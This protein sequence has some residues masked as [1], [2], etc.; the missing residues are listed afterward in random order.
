[1]K[2]VLISGFRGVVNT[3]A[4]ERLQALPTRDD[5]LVDLADAV[6][7]DIDDSGRISRRRGQSLVIPGSAH[8]L[9]SDGEH[10]LYIQD[11]TM[12]RLDRELV[13]HAV[14]LGLDPLPMSYVT[15]GSRVYHSNGTVSAV[16]EDG[17]VR[18]W[19][20]PLSATSATASLISGTM[21]AGT[22]LFAMTLLREDGQESGT[23]LAARIDLP[24]QSGIRFSW[25]VPKDPGIARAVLYLTEADGET[26]LKA[27][28]VDVGAGQY[29][30]TGGIR[31]LPLATQW[32]DKPPAGRALALYR[33]RIYLASGEHLFATTALSYEH[34]DLRDYRA[35]DGSEILLLAP[36]ESGLFVGTR[37]AIWFL[38]GA[39]FADNALVRK[40]DGPPIPG[41]VTHGDV[42]DIL[43]NDQLDGQRGVL[44]ATP[45]G[46][47]LGMPDGSLMNLTVD[48]YTLPNATAGA[49]LLRS[50]QAH[51][52]LLTLAA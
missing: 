18:S 42:G 12:Y 52:Y 20:I 32:L 22:Y 50:G 29:T 36:V 48:T 38:S 33:G 24:D 9:Y 26:L 5:P 8:S 23:G 46:V 43:G 14:A 37:R 16:F 27:A 10:C 21:A 49:A 44:F 4:V 35:I 28:E 25:T 39:S 15:V 6:N 47:V 51:Q 34:C 13:P 19:G 30:Y 17:Y 7:V 3:E 1:M 2:P 45:Q 41:T 31:S 40:L 11:E